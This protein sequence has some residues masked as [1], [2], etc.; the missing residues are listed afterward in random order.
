MTST[1]YR[2]ARAVWVQG[3]NSVDGRAFRK[4]TIAVRP[5]GHRPLWKCAE[6]TTT[7]P[8]LLSWRLVYS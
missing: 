7:D 2:L 6:S 8:A 1:F 5:G 4:G 3:P